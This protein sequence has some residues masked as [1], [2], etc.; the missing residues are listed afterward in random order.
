MTEE[1]LE[2]AIGR[3]NRR[4]KTFMSEGLSEQEAWDLADQLFERDREGLDDRRLCFEC[5]NYDTEKRTCNKIFPN[6]KAD[7]VGELRFMLQRCPHFSLRG[8]K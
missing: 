7:L 6:G 5:K 4:F 2:I 3:H 8:K 1:E